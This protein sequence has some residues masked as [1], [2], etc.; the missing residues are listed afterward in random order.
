MA[1]STSTRLAADGYTAVPN[2]MSIWEETVPRCMTARVNVEG[3]GLAEAHAALE[4]VR[5]KLQVVGLASRPELP[6]GSVVHQIDGAE[7]TPSLPD[8]VYVIINIPY[9]S[10]FPKQDWPPGWTPST[11]SGQSTSSNTNQGKSNASDGSHKNKG[12][13]GYTDTNY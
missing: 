12:N 10:I 3:K 8:N 4:Q 1:V 5:L 2:P 6:I 11:S 7:G 9:S 13:L